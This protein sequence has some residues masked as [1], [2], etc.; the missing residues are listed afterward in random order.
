[1]K[2]IIYILIVAMMLLFVG[3]TS[4][5]NA[6]TNSFQLEGAFNGGDEALGVEFSE[7]QPPEKVKDGGIQ[8]FPIR[9]LLE[10]IGENDIEEG[11]GHVS[12]AGISFTEFGITAEDASQPIPELRGV[13]QQGDNVIPGSKQFVMFQG[14]KFM[15]DLGSGSQ[16][17]TIL[18]DLCYPYTTNARAS[19]C[20]SGNTIQGYDNDLEVCSLDGNRDY[21]N[22]G[23]PVQIENVVQNTAG[24]TSI[25]IQFD[26]VHIGKSTNG[27]VYRSDVLD[28]EC[29]ING[30]PVS[31][32]N[33][34]LE[35]NYVTYFIEAGELNS[36]VDCGATGTNTE[37][38]LLSGDKTTV[39]CT[40]DT[41]GQEDYEKGIAIVLDY[42]YFDRTS[43]SIEI[44][45]VER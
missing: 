12:L 19:I 7:G 17:K 37:T 31:S 8:P 13:K 14:L 6:K 28:S 38:V 4:G 15:S 26:I 3:C 9:V 29:K 22:S 2:K 1:M 45:H 30:N 40:I 25:Q 5:T 10:N 39:F 24:A 11:E 44:E 34:A 36:G 41:T 20:V 35:E 23:A 27:R 42:D 33:A 43:V 18:L 16:E 32:T 21:A